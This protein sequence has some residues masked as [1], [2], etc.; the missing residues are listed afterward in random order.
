M[1]DGIENSPGSERVADYSTGEIH[2]VKR[3]DKD[4]GRSADDRFKRFLR[5]SR[6]AAAQAR[7]RQ[8]AWS[9]GTEEA[10]SAGLTIHDDLSLSERAMGIVKPT[11]DASESDETRVEPDGAADGSAGDAHV[12]LI[13]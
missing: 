6:K 10:D 4:S 11:A 3:M 7:K 8:D 2:R 12:D 5:Q 9:S 1:S 13:A